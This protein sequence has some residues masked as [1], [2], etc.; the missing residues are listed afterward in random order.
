[1][2]FTRELHQRAAASRMSVENGRKGEFVCRRL[3][4]GVFGNVE[5]VK[6]GREGSNQ[7]ARAEASYAALAR[8]KEWGKGRATEKGRA[9]ES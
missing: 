7:F 9:E 6:G 4:C 5:L 1:M 3:G 2:A 8:R